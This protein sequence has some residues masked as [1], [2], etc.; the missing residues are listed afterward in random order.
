ME[1]LRIEDNNSHA[2]QRQRRS[3]GRGESSL[4]GGVRR[5]DAGQFSR[6]LALGQGPQGPH[7]GREDQ[8]GSLHVGP[9]ALHGGGGQRAPYN[10][11]AANQIIRANNNGMVSL[12]RGPQS[13]ARATETIEM[14]RK[15]L[16]ELHPSK[17][18]LYSKTRVKEKINEERILDN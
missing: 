10:P 15:R 8:Q 3:R 7:E 16:L 13:Y 14:R 17:I 2:G 12:E 6:L 11:A 4:E 9:R 18:H 5:P 1:Q